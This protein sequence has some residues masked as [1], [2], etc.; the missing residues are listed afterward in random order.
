MPV[1]YVVLSKKRFILHGFLAF[2]GR[3]VY[4]DSVLVQDEEYYDICS[5]HIDYTIRRFFY[6][7][8]ILT[9]S[10]MIAIIWPSYQSL[11]EEVKITALQLKF[12]FVAENS[13]AEFAG[14]IL[15]ECNVWAHGFL[16]YI[17]IEVAMD[18]FTDYVVISRSLLE[19]RLKKMFDEFE[20]NPSANIISMLGDIVQ[21]LQNFDK[22][23]SLLKNVHER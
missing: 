8:A 6:K 23:D 7:V 21:S 1:L 20:I 5:H 11:T 15:L 12:P 16:G 3:Y 22:Y 13:Y 2:P 9:A 17:S 14:N 19:Y 18:I 10:A 4:P